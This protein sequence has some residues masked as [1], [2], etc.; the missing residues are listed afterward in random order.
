MEEAIQDL[1]LVAL[2]VPSQLSPVVVSIP[3]AVD[4][5]IVFMVANTLQVE[6]ELGN[7]Y[8]MVRWEACILLMC[9]KALI[10]PLG[11]MEYF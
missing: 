1:F 8:L 4:F 6:V 7:L 10:E 11:S 2:V 5:I 3:L 9:A